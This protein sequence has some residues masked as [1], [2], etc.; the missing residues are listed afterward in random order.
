ME[1]ATEQAKTLIPPKQAKGLLK[2]SKRDSKGG[3]KVQSNQKQE[4]TKELIRLTDSSSERKIDLSMESNA[5]TSQAPD[6]AN[7]DTMATEPRKKRGRKEVMKKE[8]TKITTSNRISENTKIKLQPSSK[9]T[10]AE[11]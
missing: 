8:S 11:K 3:L 5:L 1:E 2:L 4:Q 9:V 7:E 10:V 6:T